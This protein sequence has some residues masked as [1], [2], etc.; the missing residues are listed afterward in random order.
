MGTANTTSIAERPGRPASEPLSIWWRVLIRK[1][2]GRDWRPVVRQFDLAEVAAWAEHL[3]HWYD[4]PQQRLFEACNL[5]Q[6]DEPGFWEGEVLPFLRKLLA[7]PATGQRLVKGSEIFQTV[8][9]AIDIAELAGQY[10]ELHEA[11]P[12]R[13]KGRCPLHNERTASFFVFRTE[14][15]W[16]CFGACGDGGDV[17]ELTRRLMEKGKR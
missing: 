15:R 8:K 16:R 17:I 4:G 9:S 3:E 7:P 5:Q 12:G 14:Q 2:S 13:L 1:T 10:T 6:L 11:G